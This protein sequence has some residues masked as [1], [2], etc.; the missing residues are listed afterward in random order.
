M[1]DAMEYSL[2]IM[3]TPTCDR[4][5]SRKYVPLFEYCLRDVSLVTFL[6]PLTFDIRCLNNGKTETKS[7]NIIRCYVFLVRAYKTK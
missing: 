5:V 7:A 6:I 2:K 4:P 3:L 1:K